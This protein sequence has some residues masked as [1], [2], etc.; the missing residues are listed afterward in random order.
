[1]ILL[2][3]FNNRHESLASVL[4]EDNHQASMLKDQVL[5]Y[6]YVSL[7]WMNLRIILYEMNYWYLCW[8]STET[9]GW[10]CNYGS[11][12][13]PLEMQPTHQ[14]RK[15]PIFKPI[16]KRGFASRFQDYYLYSEHGKK[17][18]YSFYRPPYSLRSQYKS[19]WQLWN[20]TKRRKIGKAGHRYMLENFISV[21]TC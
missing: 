7:W 19:A 5:E 12:F 13:V 8:C 20:V 4:R 11:K 17:V 15:H 3:K 6:V 16:Y 1:M 2:R 18:E 10:M 21:K 9:V 14:D